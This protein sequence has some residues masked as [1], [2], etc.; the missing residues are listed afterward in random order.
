MHLL[1]P[2][3]DPC[4]QARPGPRRSGTHRGMTTAKNF[5]AQQ[6]VCR[7]SGALPGASLPGF[8]RGA[9]PPLDRGASGLRA[10]DSRPQSSCSG[11]PRSRQAAGLTRM[12]CAGRAT[13]WVVPACGSSS[14]PACKGRP[15]RAVCV[16]ECMCV[17]VCVCVCVSVCECVC[18]GCVCVSVYECVSGCEWVCVSVGCV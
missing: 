15:G 8:Q 9:C 4:T 11:L 7:P 14:F 17:C 2:A 6:S 3:R 5:R 18:V 12:Y 16:C 10:W 1:H 13:A